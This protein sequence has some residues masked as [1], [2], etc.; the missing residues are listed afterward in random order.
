[1]RSRDLIASAKD[2]L[3]RIDAVLRHGLRRLRSYLASHELPDLRQVR[4]RSVARAL[5]AGLLA[6]IIAMVLL[7]A[8]AYWWYAHDLKSPDVAIA[9]AGASV[10]YDRS[11]ET[12]L[13]QFA[14][15]LQG[16]REPVS[17]YLVAA[18]IATEDASFYNNPGVN[19]RGMT[20][21]WWRTSCR[22]AEASS[23]GAAGVRLHS[24]WRGTCT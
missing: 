7:S 19:F 15:P 4:W 2:G 20:R 21:R 24:S 17:P 12:L 1:M 6:V 18:T 14:D 11:G 23:R 3:R 8:A 16:V 13:Y 10:A 5:T 22:L 9:G